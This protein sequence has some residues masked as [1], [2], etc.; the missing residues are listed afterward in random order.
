MALPKLKYGDY[1]ETK[2]LAIVTK[3]IE[4]ITVNAAADL[5][6]CP[7]SSETLRRMINRGDVPTGHWMKQPYGDGMIYF[8][9]KAILPVLNYRKRGGQ[10]KD[11]T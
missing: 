4:F 3:P 9:D 1:P 11:K 2:G 5:E 6:E 8:I 10:E 7:V